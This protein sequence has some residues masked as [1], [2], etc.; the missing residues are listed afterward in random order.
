[1]LTQTATWLAPSV[2]SLLLFCLTVLINHT[3]YSFENFSVVTRFRS[4][5]VDNNCRGLTAD[6]CTHCDNPDS[7][8]DPDQQDRQVRLGMVSRKA[9]FL[10]MRIV[11]SKNSRHTH[12]GS[13]Y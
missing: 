3:L 6:I 12:E 10:P 9:N 13:S 2:Y 11:T 7:G 8:L 1:M 4:I 5:L